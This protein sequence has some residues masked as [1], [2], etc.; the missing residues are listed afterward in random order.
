MTNSDLPDAA[1]TAEQRVGAFVAAQGKAILGMPLSDIAS[2]CGVSDATVVRYCRH[3]GY[4]GLKDFKIAMA[5]SFHEEDALSPIIGTEPLPELKKM[6]FAGCLDALRTTATTLSNAE[7]EK[8]IQL[9]CAADNLDVYASGGSVP[10]ASYLRHQLIKLGVRTNVYS[11]RTSMLLSQSRLT[12]RDAV[13]AISH[14]GATRDIV[15]AQSS[16][17]R[18]G[19]PTIC[20]TSA[21]DSPLAAVS[22]VC[23]LAAGE[24]FLGMNTYS[25]LS[26][27]AM[28]DVL[29][30]GMAVLRQKK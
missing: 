14:T 15:D 20:M 7:L 10:I 24:H 8:A 29:Y 26:Q 19:A 2:A 30:A 12:K 4:K 6:I 18:L 28:V 11:D 21:P 17:H 3:E 1:I 16:A 25:R 13:L 27:L 9:L 23:L 5:H 22:D